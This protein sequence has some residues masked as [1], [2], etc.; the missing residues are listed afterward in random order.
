M[1]NSKNYVFLPDDIDY[2][3]D[4]ISSKMLTQLTNDVAKLKAKGA[5]DFLPKNELTLLINFAMRNIDIS[6]NLSA[7]PVS[8][9]FCQCF[10]ICLLK[11]FFF[12]DMDEDSDEL[13]EKILD[14]TEACLFISNIYATA[15]D[16][17]FL[18][19]DNM[20]KIV[21]FVQFQM[22]ETIFP[23]YDPVFSVKS[24]K[25]DNRKKKSAGISRKVQLL[26]NKLV[27]LTKIF[28]TLFDKCQFVD[29]IVL[30]VSSLA[31]EPFF[32]D[33]IETLQFACLELVTTV[34]FTSSVLYN[35]KGFSNFQ[36]PSQQIFRKAVYIKYRSSILNDI[37]SSVDRLPCSKKNL[38]PYKLMHNGGSIQM[39][40]AL[41][42]QLVQCSSVL[43]NSWHDLK[44]KR[45]QKMEVD[46]P[47]NKDLLIMEKYDQ[48]YS[49]GG[50]FLTTFLNKCRTRSGES[51]FRPLFENFI[52]DLLTTVNKPEW[53][54]SEVLLYLLSR[55]LVKYMSDKNSDQAIRV[56]SLE[57]LGLVAA[58]LR[59]DT[60]ESRCKVNTM[61]ALIKSIKLEQ[62]K[63]GDM[64]DNDVSVKRF[65]FL[66]SPTMPS[67]S[68]CIV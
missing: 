1:L 32:V 66:T 38:R 23:S 52:H 4:C 22:R 65:S 15:V 20:D 43:P 55:L 8:P 35:R 33:N 48:A 30:A 50:N 16:V 59:K 11:R 42:L 3:S 64:N 46:D 29:T 39:V 45:K 36:L 60:V 18:L 10:S 21:K 17:K 27:E 24:M 54:A 34:S 14:A 13:I 9:S 19:E 31:V 56:V 26:F 67:A 7:G 5:I 37:L 2:Y 47:V 53:P 62:E 12:Q 58:R 28:V 49:I 61:D 25:K 68:F 57:Y 63:E 44:S 40:T 41:V 6:R 51:D